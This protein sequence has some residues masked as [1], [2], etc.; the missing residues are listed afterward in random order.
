MQPAQASLPAFDLQG[1]R[2]PRQSLI[3]ASWLI[4]QHQPVARLVRLLRHHLG[5]GV[6]AVCLRKVQH[7]VDRRPAADDEQGAVGTQSP[8][9]AVAFFL[10][11]AEAHW[12]G[13]QQLS[14]RLWSRSGELG[15]HH[16]DLWV[17]RCALRGIGLVA[18]TWGY[19]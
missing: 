15:R 5:T 7:L 6:N 1:R 4:R 12:R 2:R 14:F 16:P 17:H 10:I 8:L 13:H 18:P 11:A 19:R 9:A 3:I